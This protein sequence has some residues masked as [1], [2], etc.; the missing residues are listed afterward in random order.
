[1]KIKLYTIF[2]L[3]ISFTS[4]QTLDSIIEKYNDRIDPFGKMDSITHL[5]VDMYKRIESPVNQVLIED[6]TS[7]SYSIFGQNSFS[8][9]KD[10]GKVDMNKLS[11]PTSWEIKNIIRN[12]LNMLIKKD[13][14][15]FELVE[16]NDSLL[17]V[18][19]SNSFRTVLYEIEQ[20]SYD[21]KKK[22]IRN[23]GK[24]EIIM[25]FFEYRIVD[26]I[27]VVTKLSFE[28]DV[29]TAEMSKFNYKFIKGG[30]DVLD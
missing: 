21:L 18:K 14:E 23:H 7:S 5:H 17:V 11:N 16:A 19:K 10:G 6:T 1:M 20:E 22:T 9:S 27:K 24:P 25:R 28:N 13:D 12:H 29:A 26:G 2:I 3:S 30:Y 4:G 8:N 15:S